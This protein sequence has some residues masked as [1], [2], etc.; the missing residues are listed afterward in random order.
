MAILDTAGNG[1][2][3]KD[4]RGPGLRGGASLALRL[5]KFAALAALTTAVVFVS[6]FLLFLHGLE[7]TDAPHVGRADGIVALTGGAERITD[8]VDWLRGGNGA[9]LLI[10]GVAHDVT[11][12]HLA[13]KS[14]A[15]REWLRCCI[16][17]GHAAQNT[18]GNAKETRHWVSTNGY[19]SLIVVTSSY[20]MP[21]ALVE[22]RRQLPG[23]D[24]VPAPVVTEKLKAM[25]FWR[26]PGLL[27][28]IGVEYAKFVVAYV[29]AGLTPA[30][31]LGEISDATTRRRV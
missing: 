24:L 28:T 31:P 21:R 6:G 1:S 4:K 29:R 13:Q 26:H 8:A 27:R 15:V 18:V 5:L 14:P 22:L 25:D 19:R 10:S 9:R 30:R 20:H 2:W 7:R 3:S 23:I 12:E 11:R 17:L 16:D